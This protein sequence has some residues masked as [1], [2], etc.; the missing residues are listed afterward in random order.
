MH[1]IRLF[2][3]VAGVVTILSGGVAAH[4]SQEAAPTS[5]VFTRVL[6]PIT[7]GQTAVLEGQ[8]RDSE[9]VALSASR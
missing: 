4:A 6:S 2:A 1:R 8:V 3:V 5:T 7:Y 9:G